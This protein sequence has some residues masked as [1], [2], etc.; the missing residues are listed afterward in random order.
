MTT[1]FQ[2]DMFNL[3]EKIESNSIRLFLIDLPYNQTDLAFDKN[4]IDLKKLWIELKRTGLD[5]ACYI[6][7]C[8]TKF[9]YTLIQS[10]ESWFRYDLVWNK[11][12]S[13]AGFLNAKKMPL[14]QHEMIYIFYNK[15]PLYNIEDN[16]IRINN[17]LTTGIIQGGVYD[18]KLVRST[19][20]CYE[21]KLPVSVLNFET[22]KFMKK[23]RHPTEKPIE[24]YEYLI[25]YF[26]KEDDIILDPCFGSAN[27]LVACKNLKRKY[28]G[29]ELDNTYF[30]NAIQL[31][32]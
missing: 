28:I 23:K 17:K 1:I 3:F 31:L 29:F 7:F 26:S 10:N 27:S 18:R 16:H 25:K 13:S 24:L 11:P 14:R 5:N 32:I 22:Q 2:G 20:R 30:Y 12:N 21:P 6:F 8:T 9:G 4:I 19:G 15:L